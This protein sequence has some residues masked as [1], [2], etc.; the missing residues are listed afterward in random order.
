MIQF[1]MTMANPAQKSSMDAF[2]PLE[3]DEHDAQVIIDTVPNGNA[4]IQFDYFNPFSWGFVDPFDNFTLDPWD[5][6]QE[7]GLDY[8]LSADNL[9]GNMVDFQSRLHYLAGELRHLGKDVD[10]PSY[11]MFFTPSC[12]SSLIAAF[13]RNKQWISPS[14][15]RATFEMHKASLP[16]V[17]ALAIAGSEIGPAG[18]LPITTSQT[19]K[20]LHDVAETYIFQCLESIKASPSQSSSADIKTI[21]HCQAAL[22]MTS[23]QCILNNPETRYRILNRR[24][25]EL[26]ATLRKLGWIDTRHDVYPASM[27]PKWSDFI[28]KETIIR[29]V[30]WA[31]ATSNILIIFCNQPPH[32]TV[33][34]MGGDF[35]CKEEIW[36]A[37][38]AEEFETKWKM[39]ADNQCR[40][41]IRDVMTDL[42]SLNRTKA[43]DDSLASM[44]IYDLQAVQWGK[45]FLT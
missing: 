1:L 7:V 13:F 27:I 4:S 30:T 23:M 25:P 42:T 10:E 18:H 43:A 6:S 28:S 36:N 40:S 44:T 5:G 32:M 45:P 31:F 38:T 20:S 24:M 33:V 15:V 2:Q 34:E 3:Q 19:A 11:S 17:L 35:P 37:K 29:L 14:L 41:S 21:E 26:I 9:D 16:L 22:I 8:M 12:F 39:Y